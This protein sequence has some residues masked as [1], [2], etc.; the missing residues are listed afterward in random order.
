MDKKIDIL[1]KQLTPYIELFN[2]LDIYFWF[3]SGVVSDYLLRKIRV[4]ITRSKPFGGLNMFFS[5]EESRLKV[6]DFLIERGFKKIKDSTANRDWI[7]SDRPALRKIKFS[8]YEKNLPEEH[9][10]LAGWAQ[11]IELHGCWD[12]VNGDPAVIAKSPAVSRAES[13]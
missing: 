1:K 4:E 3:A 12:G 8:L 13:I 11:H 9:K 5:S 2:D 6:C 10:H 7:G